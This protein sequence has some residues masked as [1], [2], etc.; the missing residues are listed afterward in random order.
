MN[1][2]LNYFPEGFMTSS[3]ETVRSDMRML[4]VRG[5][6]NQLRITHKCQCYPILFIIVRYEEPHC[7]NVLMH[8]YNIFQ[9]IVTSKKSLMNSAGLK[10][11]YSAKMAKL[12][13]QRMEMESLHYKK[14]F[15][16]ST[17]RLECKHFGTYE[18]QNSGKRNHQT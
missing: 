1:L 17:I 8:G 7:K 9:I 18:S 13:N 5:V 11:L 3:A 4:F 16:Y 12:W 14:D 2:F 10:V 6:R 15:V